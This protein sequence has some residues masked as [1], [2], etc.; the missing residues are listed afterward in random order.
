MQLTSEETIRFIN[1]GITIHNSDVSV[2]NTPYN[3]E[4]YLAAGYLLEKYQVGL[5][6][7][8]SVHNMVTGFVQS[9]FNREEIGS[10]MYVNGIEF[11]TKIQGSTLCIYAGPNGKLIASIDG[12]GLQSAIKVNFGEGF[13]A[14]GE[15]IIRHAD[16]GKERQ[17]AFL[18]GK[19]FPVSLVSAAIGFAAEK[20]SAS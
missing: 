6:V 9:A 14:H 18:I 3:A 11:V 19:Y 5:E 13:S 20:P 1:V 4:D 12:K 7:A 10:S 16:I 8:R 17:Q 15:V 2:Q